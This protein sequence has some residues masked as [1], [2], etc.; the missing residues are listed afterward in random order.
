[1]G[2]EIPTVILSRLSLVEAPQFS[3]NFNLSIALRL[4][5]DVLPLRYAASSCV[6]THK[7]PSYS[8]KIPTDNN[9][10][11]N[12]CDT[13]DGNIPQVLIPH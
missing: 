5:T 12:R 11:C 1:M 4:A 7:V 8:R 13:L 2:N 10:S 6:K 9:F 3:R